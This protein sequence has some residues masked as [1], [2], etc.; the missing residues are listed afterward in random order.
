MVLNQ[1]LMSYISERDALEILKK[2]QY[3]G[4]LNSKYNKNNPS[5]ITNCQELALFDAFD[6]HIANLL[7][8]NPSKLDK[9]LMAR[10]RDYLYSVFKK[11]PNIVFESLMFN[12]EVATLLFTKEQFNDISKYK[13][14]STIK[15]KE[16]YEKIKKG[17]RTTTEESNLLFSFLIKNIDNENSNI[18]NLLDD[19]YSKLLNLKEINNLKGK[20]FVL[21]YTAHIARKDLR[22]PPVE[23]YLTNTDLSNN[24]YSSKNYGTSYGNTGII[25][26]NKDLVSNNVTPMPDISSI[27]KFMQTICHETK[28]SSQ[29][30]KSSINDISYE[31]FEWIRTSIF[32]NYL[33]KD[34]Y[35]EYQVNY[36]HNEI[37]RDANLYGWRMVERILNKYAPS[38]K[39]EIE[40][41]ISTNI[42][43][44]YKGAYA[45]KRDTKKRMPKEYYNVKMMDEIIAK[46]P[47][48]IQTYPQLSYIYKATGE[49]KSFIELIEI[50]RRLA[51]STGKIDVDKIFYDYFIADIKS[52]VLSTINVNSLDKEKQYN[53]FKCIS[54]IIINEI[55]LISR[56][57]SVLSNDNLVTFEHINKERVTRIHHLLNYLN[58][59]KI[60]INNL[61]QEDIK[62][63]N[64]RAFG[65]RISIID[66]KLESLQRKF[67]KYN[68]NIVQTSIYDDLMTL[69]GSDVHGP[70]L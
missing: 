50:N 21:K 58:S 22:I 24:S 29:A 46:N 25:S 34:N 47:S 43:E 59:H 10:Y 9:N 49:R 65:F 39:Q 13:K 68:S 41:V 5:Y 7:L 38:R 11:I 26:V 20:E 36:Q 28:H 37:E 62:E 51:N 53:L 8:N 4:Y 1:R 45:N 31:S 48:L 69:A 17:S 44:F 2:G 67:K 16:I 27:I 54:D 63:I 66:D 6:N 42:V 60:L 30:Y 18:I 3:N 70:H 15:C 64:K 61:I 23:V 57:M 55:D 19:V 12:K 52:G 40:S 32:R 14:D 35:N 33:S 56:S